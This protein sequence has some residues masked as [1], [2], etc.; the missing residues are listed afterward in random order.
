M[1]ISTTEFVHRRCLTLPKLRPDLYN[2]NGL[3]AE[4]VLDESVRTF[5]EKQLLMEIDRA[6]DR[7]DE[8]AFIQSTTELKKN[9]H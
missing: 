1:N 8:Q 5:R 4:M 9:K 7:K 3:F 2:M 6:L